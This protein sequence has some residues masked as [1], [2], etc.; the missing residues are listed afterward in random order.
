MTNSNTS[1]SRSSL[2]SQVQLFTDALGGATDGGFV[3]DPNFRLP[4][5]GPAGEID[6]H[7]PESSQFYTI[8]PSKLPNCFDGIQ[9]FLNGRGKSGSVTAHPFITHPKMTLLA[10]HYDGTQGFE[11]DSFGGHHGFISCL[12][13]LASGGSSY[14][15]PWRYRTRSSENNFGFLD[16][17][18]RIRSYYPHRCEE[19][20]FGKYATFRGIEGRAY[21]VLGRAKPG[22]DS[23]SPIVIEQAFIVYAMF[24]GER[25]SAHRMYRKLQNTKIPPRFDFDGLLLDVFGEIP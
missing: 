13:K 3:I 22:R 17:V 7:N 6:P 1:T 9:Y 5:D 12:T 18:E 4:T 23:R 20:L 24:E 2:P 25:K 21:E 16:A 15:G 11:R 14:L 19:D 10:Q 8:R